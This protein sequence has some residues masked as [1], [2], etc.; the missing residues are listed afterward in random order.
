VYLPGVALPESLSVTDDLASLADSEIV[1]VVVPS[2]GFREVVRSF[3][4]HP[5]SERCRYLVSATKGIEGGT[6]ARMSEVSRHEAKKAKAEV[7]FAVISGPSFAKE[8]VEGSPTAAVIACDDESA[9]D[10]LQRILS[11][12]N[13]R[14]YSTSDVVGVELGGT[15]KNVIAIAAGVVMGLGLGNNARAALITRGL[16][17]M[18]RFGIACGGHPETFS[19]LAGLGDLVLTCTSRMSRNQRIGEALASGKTLAEIAAGTAMVAE[20]IRNCK[21][22]LSLA[23]SLGLEMPITEQMVRVLYDGKPPRLAVETLMAR[24]LKR[25]VEP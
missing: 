24:E 23:E 21:A 19:G 5:S 20:G 10:H 1:L 3:L 11:G 15:V 14:L 6:H 12:G 17:E 18:T 9:A 22:V 13:L 7:C 8:L 25:E 2:H 4:S 16:H